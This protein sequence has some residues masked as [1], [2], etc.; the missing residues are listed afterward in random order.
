M[1]WRGLPWIPI[2]IAAAIL[3][4][5]I[6]QAQSADGVAAAAAGAAAPSVIMWVLV[7]GGALAVLSLGFITALWVSDRAAQRAQRRRAEAE[8]RAMVEAWRRSDRDAATAL[9][10]A[11]GE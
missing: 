6:V 10:H 1:T 4:T 7:M 5:G 2:A 8:R 3:L 9:D 11:A